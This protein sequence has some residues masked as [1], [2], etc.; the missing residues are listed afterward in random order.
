MTES[1]EQ[2]ARRVL[3]ALRDP[4]FARWPQEERMRVFGLASE[5]RIVIADLLQLA[6]EESEGRP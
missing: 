2:A 6:L 4:D 5:R 3:F 1:Q